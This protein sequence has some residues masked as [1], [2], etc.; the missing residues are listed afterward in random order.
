MAAKKVD[1][2]LVSPR[3]LM[4]MGKKNRFGPT[5]ECKKK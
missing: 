5:A 1:T 2:K 4:A 3:K